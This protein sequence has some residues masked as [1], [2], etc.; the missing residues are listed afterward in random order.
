MSFSIICSI[1]HARSSEYQVYS[2][3]SQGRWHIPSHVFFP[4][5]LTPLPN[6]SYWVSSLA[7]TAAFPQPRNCRQRGR[8]RQRRRQLF[9]TRFGDA[10][11]I[12]SLAHDETWWVSGVM[13]RSGGWRVGLQGIPTKKGYNQTKSQQ[14]IHVWC[15]DDSELSC[16]ATGSPFEIYHMIIVL[17]WV[18][19]TGLFT[20]FHKEKGSY[21]HIYLYW[22]LLTSDFGD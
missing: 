7:A 14:R 6:H 11:A 12:S 20:H 1:I 13:G 19:Q 15:V 9:H 4:Y 2:T 22:P 18:K 21:S 3:T 16:F 10:G 17:H 5:E 8:L